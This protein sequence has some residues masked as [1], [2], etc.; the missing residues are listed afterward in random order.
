[1]STG[2]TLLLP[3]GSSPRNSLHLPPRTQTDLPRKTIGELDPSVA[4]GGKWVGDMVAK[5]VTHGIGR[6]FSQRSTPA[7]RWKTVFCHR[8]GVMT[9]PLFCMC[10]L[11]PWIF[12]FI[13]E[14]KSSLIFTDAWVLTTFRRASGSRLS[15]PPSTESS[16]VGSI[17][18]LDLALLFSLFVTNPTTANAFSWRLHMLMANPCKTVCRRNLSSARNKC[19]PHWAI[20]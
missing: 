10:A 8:N 7:D 4:H 1:M 16:M 2:K 20:R 6:Q 9:E 14:P 11:R 3:T 13:L 15:I 19:C 5:R 17:L 18:R 12:V